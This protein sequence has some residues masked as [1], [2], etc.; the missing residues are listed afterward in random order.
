MFAIIISIY[1]LFIDVDVES[2]MRIFIN[3]T[4]IAAIASCAF[5]L[6]NEMDQILL[7]HT[8]IGDSGSGNVNTIA[9]YLSTFAIPILFSLIFQKKRGLIIIYSILLFFILLT[10]SKK[11]LLYIISSI[12]LFAYLKN[13][14][15]L[16]K[17][18]PYIFIFTIII[19]III[20]VQYLYNIIGFRVLDFLGTLGLINSYYMP[21]HS[22]E[23]RESMIQVGIKLFLYHP[24]FGNG[25]GYFTKYSGFETYSHN[26][27]IEL[28]VNYGIF[29]F[30]L[31]YYIY[32]ILLYRLAIIYKKCKSQYSILFITLLIVSLINDTAY[33]SFSFNLINYIIFIIVYI[34]TINYSQNIIPVNF[35]LSGRA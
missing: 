7:G 12:A 33:V 17:Y 9:V 19:I 28:L 10:G 8:R 11:G 15:R 23:L 31:Y 13:K 30:A 32:M 16:I 29:G 35:S 14:L 25:W 20:R 5:I 1:L 21:S 34:Y 24:L 26:N 22:T 3:T 18:I 27:M 6:F 4:I 2:L